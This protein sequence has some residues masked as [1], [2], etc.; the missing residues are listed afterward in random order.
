MPNIISDVFKKDLL[1]RTIDFGVDIINIALMTEHHE[2][3]ASDKLWADVRCN[4]IKGKGYEAGGQRLCNVQFE[5]D[6]NAVHITGDNVVWHNAR[7]AMRSIVLYF[8][9]SGRIIGT[10]G[11]DFDYRVDD[12]MFTVKW[13]NRVVIIETFPDVPPEYLNYYFEKEKERDGN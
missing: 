9:G 7:F 12:A 6:S 3:N 2:Y 10:T 13:D 5:K 8:A 4:E 11:F 1:E